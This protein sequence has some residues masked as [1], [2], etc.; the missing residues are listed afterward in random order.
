MTDKNLAAIKIQQ[1]WRKLHTNNYS[2]NDSNNDSDND[3]NNDSEND[4]DNDS[5]IL[6]ISN[7]TDFSMINDN[8]IMG[9]NRELTCIHYLTGM[10]KICLEISIVIFLP[11]SIYLLSF[12]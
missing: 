8:N 4:S 3:S 11:F 6:M 12:N 2:D 9:E 10:F 1:W 7:I 5:D